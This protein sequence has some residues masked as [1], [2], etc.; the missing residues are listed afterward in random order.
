MEKNKKGRK[1]QHSAKRVME[2][3]IPVFLNPKIAEGKRTVHGKA[4]AGNKKI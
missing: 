1:N 3:L 2:P 4:A